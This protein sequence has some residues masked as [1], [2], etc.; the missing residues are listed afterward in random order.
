MEMKIM[1]K[2][3]CRI[4]NEQG[5]TLFEL[6]VVIAII[7]ALLGLAFPVFQ[8][9][10]DRAKK[11]QAK[12]DVTQI[13]TAVNAFYT[14]YGKYPLVTADTIYG[15]GGTSSAD[16]FYSLRAVALG[17]NAPVNGVPAVNSRAIVFIS[18]AEDTSQT[19]PKGKIGSTGH[20][21]DPWGQ[22]YKIAIDGNYDNQI[23]NPYTADTGA[24]PGTLRQGVLAWSYGKDTKL[25][26]NGD[27]KY[28]NSDDVISW[29]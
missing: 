23:T 12:N 2:S 26:N 6:L 7:A 24:G 9:V 15:A 25:G 19:N 18:P 3:E 22:P 27:G 29:Q 14:E 4:T 17:A 11:V 10:L 28:K 21:C 16:L 13:V 8:G 20:F 1:T 5:F